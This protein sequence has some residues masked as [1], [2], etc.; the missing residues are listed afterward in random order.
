MRGLLADL[1]SWDS[2]PVPE[3]ALTLAE[4]AAAHHRAAWR[5]HHLVPDGPTVRATTD[6]WL[7]GTPPPRPAGEEPGSVV[8]DPGGCRIDA[9]AHLV[10]LRIT[11]PPAFAETADGGPRPNGVTPADV[12]HVAGD[13]TE[14]ARLYAEDTTRPAAWGGLS[15]LLGAERPELLRA[16]SRSVTGRADQPPP[17]A[18]LTRWLA[19]ADGA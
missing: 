2:D 5:A 4:R 12:A 1:R 7:R 15:L 10:R 8:T 9:Y 3:P 17:P 18:E 13:L 19:A 6:A 16:V 11:D 14:A